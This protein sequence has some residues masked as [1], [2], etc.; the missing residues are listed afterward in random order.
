MGPSPVCSFEPDE[1]PS[2]FSVARGYGLRFVS[3]LAETL[4]IEG[5]ALKSATEEFAYRRE[6]EA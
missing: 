1:N 3:P 2:A 4:L 5:S 6:A